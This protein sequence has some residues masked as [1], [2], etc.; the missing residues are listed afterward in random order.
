MSWDS[1]VSGSI[2][3]DGIHDGCLAILGIENENSGALSL[4]LIKFLLR[5]NQ[6]SVLTAIAMYNA[7]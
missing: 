3:S 4:M 7:S 2:S 6:P 5:F 1:S